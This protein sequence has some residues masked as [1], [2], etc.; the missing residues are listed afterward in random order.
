MS[1]AHHL[2]VEL[3]LALHG[4]FVQQRLDA[5]PPGL[6]SEMS[7]QGVGAREAAPAAPVA[8]RA[9]FAAADEF[10]FAAV[11][12]LVP[13]A[14]VLSGKGLAADG[15]DEGPLV[16]VR[17]QVRAEVVGACEA[18]GAEVALE[19][20]GVFLDTF[21]GARSRWSGRVVVF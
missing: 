9:E 17:A 2:L 8:P 10:L 19:G 16:G 1:A 11:Q 18:F 3:A 14:V 15:A 20:C 7:P 5:D 12:A 13:F 6:A 4:L 21:L